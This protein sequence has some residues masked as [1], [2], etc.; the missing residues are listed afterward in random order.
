MQRRTIESVWGWGLVLVLF[1]AAIHPVRGQEREPSSGGAK[2]M[3]AATFQGLRLRS[4]GP[5]VT[6]GRGVDFAVDPTNGARYFVAV[7]WGGVWKTVNAGTTWTPV[8]DTYGSYSIGALALDPRNP[9]ILWVGTGELNSQRS[10]GYGDGLY[11]SEDGGRSFRRVGLEKSEHI[12]RIVIDPRNSQV[13]YVAAQ[14]PLWSAG[15]E[16]GLYKT[17]DGGKTWSQV[18]RISDDTGVTEVVLDPSNPDTLY[19]AAWQRRRHVW[20][21]ING[22]PESAVYKSTDGGQNW[23]KLRGGLPAVLGR[24]GLAV[25]PVDPR[26]VYA[27]VE[28]AETGSGIYRSLDRGATWERMNPR[29]A[30]AMYYG[31]ILCDPKDVDRIYLPDV[32]F[33][34]SDDAGRT[35]KPLG[36]KN[37][38]VDNHTIWIDPRHPDYY[39]VGSDGGIYESFD[40]GANWHFK[41]NMPI[42][43]FYD[44]TVDQSAPFY[45]VC[46]GTQDN[47]TWC[48][49]SR[50]TS[51]SGI[52]NADWYVV[53]GGDGFHARVDPVDPNI[54]YATSQYG[55]L[56]RFDRRTGERIGL[57]PKEGKGEPPL[58]WNWD[59]P[60]L[61][62]PHAPARLYFAANRLFR[63]DDRGDSWRAISPDLTRQIDRDSLPVMGRI[64]GPEAIAKHQ[65]TSFYGNIV[66]LAESPRREGLLYVGTDDGLIQVTEDG[67]RTW[68]KT[69]S[70]PGVPERT[71]VARILAS[72]HDP[73]VAYAVLNNHKNGDFAPYLLKTID[74]GRSW[75]SIAGNLPG[76]HPLWAIAE[77]HV[78]RDLLFVGT[79]FGLFVTLD[80]GGKWTALKGGLPTIA[81]RD[82]AIQKRENDLVVGTFGRG[83]YIL[84]NY[85]PLREVD[86]ALLD[87]E[88]HLFAPRPSLLHVESTP[89]GG[90]GKAFQGE[91]F[92][93]AD[94]PPFGATLTYYLKE[95]LPTR[96]ERRLE[97]ERKLRQT[98][99]EGK[100]YQYP[101]AEALAAEAK[102]EPPQVELTIRDAAGQVVRRLSGATTAGL[103]R[104]TWDL[105]YPAPQLAPPRPPGDDV[106]A[107]LYGPPR[108]GHLVMPGRYTV[109]LA[110]RVDG[111]WTSLGSPQPLEV[112]TEGSLALAAADR[113]TLFAFQQK[114]ASLQR[115]VSGAVALA[116]ETKAQ[117]ANARR[118]LQETPAQT[119]RLLA[120][121]LALDQRLQ[122]I[123][124]SL[125]GDR[126]LAARYEN[127]PPSITSRVGTVAAATRQA[128]AVPT[129]TQRVQ[130]EIVAEEFSAVLVQLKQLVEGDLER[131]R[132]GLESVGAPWTSGRVPKWVP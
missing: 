19:A 107:E 28:A 99:P 54:V 109:S 116:N 64:W 41:S 6:G 44:V 24:V 118:A 10:V 53:N 66:A 120:E 58:R 35:L 119:E 1:G 89:Y 11:K 102:E 110:R 71:Y 38:H 129:Q 87:R 57:Q 48:G 32:V 20:T 16:R 31:Q 81:V 75:Q 111:V 98:D 94:N 50:T 7:A 43:Q 15:G 67:G 130:Y 47:Y 36:E 126:A 86:A 88:G 92:Y 42:A 39:L 69:E 55:G 95:K 101:S 108:S 22:G 3:E 60:L 56:V 23:T 12:A 97:A 85:A 27:T 77:D 84:D 122:V 113:E 127:A 13:V 21:L 68:R 2:G 26:V 70:L 46:G 114:A 106:L 45:Q 34:V 62:S 14:G 8:F 74:T 78:R 83:I 124:R 105:R 30:Q 112:V 104:V 96:R 123:L 40:R 37:K 18:L 115:A 76:H 29:I 73:A 59:S 9:A 17:T 82:L 90:R 72:A 65:S 128:N 5:A 125:S 100:G 51:Q 93:T 61:I 63:S 33:Q 103:Q 49:P 131:L 91:S 52:T 132:R 25:S 117:L 121:V 4:I 80:G 79:E